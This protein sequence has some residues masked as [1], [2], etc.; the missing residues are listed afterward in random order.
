MQG[1]RSMNV[2]KNQEKFIKDDVDIIVATIA[3]GMG[4]DKP[5]VR[6]VIHYDLPKNL[7]GYYQETGRAGRDGLSSDCILF[8][9]YADKIKIEYFIKEKEDPKEQEIAYDKLQ[10][11]LQYCDTQLCRR[12]VILE[13]FGETFKD[14]KC[15]NC[16]NCLKEREIFD[17]TVA[18]QKVLSC[19]ARVNERFGTTYV[20]DV[21][22]GSK[23]ERII[24]NRHNHL[25]TFGIG[26]EYSKKQWQAIIRELPQLGFLKIETNTSS[27]TESSSII[28]PK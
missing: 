11:M 3:F 22:R 8:F 16:D 25:P 21:L 6:F 19:I 27:T 23:I 14:S 20:I 9:S 12:K 13:Y 7:E 26:A 10:Q 2:L 17:G 18:A 5:D 4:I 15:N 28:Y 24:H 1:W